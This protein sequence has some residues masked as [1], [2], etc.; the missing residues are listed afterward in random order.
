MAG[1]WLKM[2][3]ATPDKPE[4]LAI[5]SA[6]GWDDPD[7]TVGKLFRLW[8]WFDQ[9]TTDGN[10]PRVTSSLLD[11]VVGVTGFVQAVADEGWLSITTEGICLTNFDRHNGDTAKN[12]ALTAKRVAGHK[13]NA[14][15]NA[16][17]N[18]STVSESVTYALPRGRG[19]SKSTSLRSVDSPA[20]LSVSDLVA[21]GVD[22]QC[23]VDWLKV[24][25][26]KRA[27]L[28]LTA[29]NEVKAEAEKAGLSPAEAVKTSAVNSWQ[30]FRAKWLVE[31]RASPGKPSRHTGFSEMDYSVGVNEDG[32]IV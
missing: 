25:K 12:R 5:T 9:Q 14:K 10:A 15:G 30:G 6:M 26:E 1:P 3:C 22:H 29:W 28:T 24:R 18:A 7:L 4:V 31:A 19:R 17:G 11:R 2:E 21:E 16:E 32:T 8:R 27:P 20:S 23:A 13:A